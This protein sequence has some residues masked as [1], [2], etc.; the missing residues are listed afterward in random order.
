MG[1]GSEQVREFTKDPDWVRQQ[2][3]DWNPA[4][5]SQYVQT[6]QMP[7]EKIGVA[8]NSGKVHAPI[9]DM[10]PVMGDRAGLHQT[11]N[12]REVTRAMANF[13][14]AAAL[15]QQQEL[16]ELQASYSQQQAA[17]QRQQPAAQQAQPEPAPQPQPQQQPD[18]AQVERARQEW[19][20]RITAE[21]KQLSTGEM[22]AYVALNNLHAQWNAIPEVR[23]RN[24]LNET[25][26]RNPARY[27]QIQQ[28]QREYQQ[29]TAALTQEFNHH[30]EAR[31]VREQQIAHAQ[32]K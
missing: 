10:S 7:P 4:Q 8:S 11:G 3:P 6:E 13:R 2:R 14:E 18:P 30:H 27:Q 29:R 16:A 17:E 21:L 24:A 19:D 1:V 23:D 20:K 9:D 5:V 32:T 31:Q 28:A 15:L 12:I 26:A 25:Y 22:N